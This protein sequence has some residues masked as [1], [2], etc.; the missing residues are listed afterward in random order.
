MVFDR[1]TID[2]VALPWYLVA[3][4]WYLVALPW[5]SVALPWYLV[6]LPWYLVALPRYLVAF[7]MP[8]TPK[9]PKSMPQTP[10]TPGDFLGQIPCARSPAPRRRRGCAP[11]HPAGNPLWQGPPTGAR[12]PR[13]PPHTQTYP[14]TPLF[15]AQIYN[16]HTHTHTHTVKLGSSLSTGQD[17]PRCSAPL[18]GLAR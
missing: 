11:R 10:R 2:L 17:L 5:Y 4:P 16:R 9:T 6:A 1:F 18:Q 15:L 8:Q 7:P 13:A 3:L 12:A 14:K